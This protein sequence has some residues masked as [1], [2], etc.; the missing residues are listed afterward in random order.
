MMMTQKAMKGF[1][2]KAVTYYTSRNWSIDEA[3]L[4]TVEVNG[5]T[6]IYL[7]VVSNDRH[8]ICKYVNHNIAMLEDESKVEKYMQVAEK[9]LS[10]QHGLSI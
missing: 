6:T 10:K 3:T 2:D 4:T 7:K 1:I 5:V 8:E 9:Y